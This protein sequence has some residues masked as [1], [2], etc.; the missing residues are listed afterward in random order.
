MPPEPLTKGLPPPDPRSVPCPQLKLLKPTPEKNSWVRHWF[1][2]TTDYYL[3]LSKAS[4]LSL[5]LTFHRIHWVQGHIIR[6]KVVV[7]W[8]WPF[9]S[10]QCRNQQ[11][12]ALKKCFHWEQG[13]LYIHVLMIINI[14]LGMCHKKVP[15]STGPSFLI[16]QHKL[17]RLCEYRANKLLCLVET[18]FWLWPE[19]TSRL[20]T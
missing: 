10:L 6:S 2:T 15:C 8:P 1:T 12:T 17:L 7:D 11:W 3:L 4:G 14:A 13:Q 5:E 16:L 20:R 18:Y 9:I 19:E